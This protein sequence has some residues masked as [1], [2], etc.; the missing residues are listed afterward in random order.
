MFERLSTTREPLICHGHY[1]LP[2]K[3]YRPIRWRVNRVREAA[4]KKNSWVEYLVNDDEIGPLL[5]ARIRVRESLARIGE[6]RILRPEWLPKLASSTLADRGEKKKN[7]VLLAESCTNGCANG[8]KP[9][10]F[11]FFSTPYFLSSFVY[12]QPILNRFA[13]MKLPRKVIEDHLLLIIRRRRYFTI[14]NLVIYH[15]TCSSTCLALKHKR[16][17]KYAY[18]RPIKDS[19]V[20]VAVDRIRGSKQRREIFDFWFSFDSANVVDGSYVEIGGSLGDAN[21]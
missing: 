6:S 12:L 11:Y 9:D 2:K 5:H 8:K 19:F 3:C 14:T 18:Y 4:W 1:L 15:R 13:K 21:F 10:M 16:V 7:N 17:V 20:P